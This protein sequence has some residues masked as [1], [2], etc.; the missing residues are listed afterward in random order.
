MSYL[1][2]NFTKSTN[3]N[4]STLRVR[5]AFIARNY[6]LLFLLLNSHT[7]TFNLTAL[8]YKST[9]DVWK[10][11]NENFRAISRV[12]FS[13]SYTLKYTPLGVNFPQSTYYWSVNS[14]LNLFK[15][16]PRKQALS[17]P[18]LSSV[19]YTYPY[20][21]ANPI[22]ITPVTKK[23]FLLTLNKFL[24]MSLDLWFH[25][26]NVYRIES[27]FSNVRGGYLLL[28]FLNK[29]YFKVYNV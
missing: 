29:Y 11:V 2:H 26:P 5:T 20:F 17:F 24:R 10:V 19:Y 22:V 14:L 8:T 21:K 25:W 18:T 28:R 4:R 9:R 16:K 3:T 15:L 13:K 23:P 7:K 12:L 6:Q 1:I 27:N